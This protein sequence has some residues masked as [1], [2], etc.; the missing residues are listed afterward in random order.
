MDPEKLD[1]AAREIDWS[2]PPELDVDE[3]WLHL[4]SQ[5]LKLLQKH[6]PLSKGYR[7]SR[8]P[9]WLDSEL[10]GFMRTRKRLWDRFKNTNS[11]EDYSEYKATR[12]KCSLLKRDKRIK[13]ELS[14]A[15]KSRT[16]PK[17]LF[18]YIRRSLKSGSGIPSLRI[19]GTDTLL[20][21][22]F[23][24]ATALAD[25]YASVY[26]SDSPTPV[27]A[28]LPDSLLCELLIDPSS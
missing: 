12:N 21:D 22:D 24:K 6:A 5:L 27:P 7:P 4:R 19:P 11:H 28:T 13:Y 15:E 1:N 18:S 9:P 3:A 2:V 17:L 25:Q 16:S 8:G 20:H 14:L 23:E 26:E 10:R